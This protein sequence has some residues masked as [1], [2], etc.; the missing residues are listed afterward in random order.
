MWFSSY[1]SNRKQFIQT[2]AIKTSKL[3]IIRRVPQ[4]STGEWR[5]EGGP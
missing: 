1:L 3:D 5:G 4:R 2:G